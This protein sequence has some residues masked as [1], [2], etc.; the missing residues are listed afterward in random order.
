MISKHAFRKCFF[1][2]AANIKAQTWLSATR[3][4]GRSALAAAMGGNAKR[5][6]RCL[7][8]P[9]YEEEEQASDYESE[10]SECSEALTPSC[11]ETNG[12]LCSM[13]HDCQRTPIQS[14]ISPTLP[15]GQDNLESPTPQ[16]SLEKNPLTGTI[17]RCVSVQILTARPQESTR[18]TASS[19]PSA[20][21]EKD[22]TRQVFQA[23]Y[24]R[25][26]VN[27]VPIKEPHKSP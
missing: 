13:P 19:W 15:V 27:T 25:Q 26:G 8:Q 3:S 6:C 12:C 11:S 4:V 22:G 14:S 24:L 1:F 10:Y 17:P 21:W 5:Q 2:A 18:S 9:Q 7:D 23:G 20:V 16:S